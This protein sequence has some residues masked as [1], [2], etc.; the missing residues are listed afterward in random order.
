MPSIKRTPLSVLLVALITV[1]TAEAQ[2]GPATARQTQTPSFGSKQKAEIRQAQPMPKSRENCLPLGGVWANGLCHL[3]LKDKIAISS[4]SA[5]LAYPET[6]EMC[7]SLTGLWSDGKCYLSVNIEAKKGS[8]AALDKNKDQKTDE[9]KCRERGG[10]WKVKDGK[11]F[12]FEYIKMDPYP[13][14]KD[15]IK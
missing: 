6:A 12:C 3:F 11:G 13:Y 5:R 8:V 7:Q 9:E 15:T 10:V 1:F 14:P 4:P 2:T